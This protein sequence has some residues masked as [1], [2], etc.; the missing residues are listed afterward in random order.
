MISFLLF[1]SDH[2]FR[3]A[4]MVECINFMLVAQHHVRAIMSSW[5]DCSSHPACHGFK[6]YCFTYAGD[7]QNVSG[8]F[9]LDPMWWQRRLLGCSCCFLSFVL[10]IK[11]TWVT[12]K[13]KRC[14][15]VT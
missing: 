9:M 6:L 13:K 10:K 8:G 3:G 11:C 2:L 7:T 12:S 1:S 5:V 15:W 4:N 14:L